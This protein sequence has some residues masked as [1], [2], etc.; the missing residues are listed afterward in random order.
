MNFEPV[1]E[2]KKGETYSTDEQVVGT[3]IDGKPIYRKVIYFSSLTSIS[4]T[5]PNMETVVTLR[6]MSLS[7]GG[8]VWRAINEAYKIDEWSCD[9][10]ARVDTGLIAIQP[11]SN[12]A[13]EHT[14]AYAIV[15]YTKTTD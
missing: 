7:N 2:V 8:I 13:A 3:W 9:I 14:T 12:F 15:E 10:Y 1:E 4:N 5:I 11:G 6:A